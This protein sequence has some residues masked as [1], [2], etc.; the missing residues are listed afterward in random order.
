[1]LVV[2]EEGVCFTHTVVP[3]VEDRNGDRGHQLVPLEAPL[4]ALG[5]LQTEVDQARLCQL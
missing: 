4:P 2:E 1:M 5:L 3:L